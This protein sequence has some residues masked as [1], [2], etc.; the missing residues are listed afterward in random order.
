M[1][2]SL[3]FLLLAVA[4]LG[5]VGCGEQEINQE[6][7]MEPTIKRHVLGEPSG[8]SMGAGLHRVGKGSLKLIE[9]QWLEDGGGH[10]VAWVD[11]DSGESVSIPSADDEI[12]RVEV[13]PAV[14]AKGGE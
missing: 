8:V 13:I 3:R 1:T 12:V 14:E 4:L 6:Q 7:Q 2:P 10:G 11:A 5:A 9:K